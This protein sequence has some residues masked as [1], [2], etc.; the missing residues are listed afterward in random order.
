MSDTD[1]PCPNCGRPCGREYAVV[2]DG[3]CQLWRW[4]NE[5]N[6]DRVDARTIADCFAHTSRRVRA[7]EAEVTDLSASKRA[8][9][10]ALGRRHAAT[11][12]CRADAE[13]CDPFPDDARIEVA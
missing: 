1:K 9:Q 12:Q 11:N 2:E 6:M 5:C 8:A 13:P 3:K 4:M 7:L 10:A